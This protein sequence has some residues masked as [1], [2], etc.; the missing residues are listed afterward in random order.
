MEC[1]IQED[2][3]IFFSFTVTP[4]AKVIQ[5]E[6]TNTDMDIEVVEHIGE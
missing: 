4:P 1:K 5:L 3:I 2:V 6:E